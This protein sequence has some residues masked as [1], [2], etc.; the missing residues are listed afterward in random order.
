MVAGQHGHCGLSVPQSVTL[1][2]KQEIDPAIH[3]HHSMGAAAVLAHTCRQET[4]TP[5]P[6]QVLH[7]VFLLCKLCMAMA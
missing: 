7:H 3:P 4:A 5:I 2:S 6:A 1:A